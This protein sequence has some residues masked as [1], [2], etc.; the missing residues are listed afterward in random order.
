SGTTSASGTA[1]RVLMLPSPG[2]IP[3][4]VENH[5]AV[6]GRS[7]PPERTTPTPCTPG[8]YGTAGGP[9]YDVPVAHSTSSG[10]MGAAATSTSAAP[11]AATGTSRRSTT[12]GSPCRCST[13]A[14]TGITW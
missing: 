1:Q 5:T 14:R 10:V 6:P 11:S 8:T 2:T 3:A 12:G 9:T 7:V 4:E 13:A